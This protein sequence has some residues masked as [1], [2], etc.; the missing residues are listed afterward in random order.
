MKGYAASDKICGYFAG[1]TDGISIDKIIL[2]VYTVI[3][4]VSNMKGEHMRRT[5]GQ[6]IARLQRK[7]IPVNLIVCILCIIASLSLFFMPLV[8]LELGVI[9]GN[10]TIKKLVCDFAVEKVNALVEDVG[11]ETG[12]E[13]GGETPEN[14]DGG[15][16]VS[17][18][19]K[20][21]ENDGTGN[22]DGA[23]NAGGTEGSDGENNGGD[24][25]TSIKDLLKEINVR[26]L[27]EPIVNEVMGAIKASVSVSA[28]NSLKVFMAQDKAE[29]FLDELFFNE[30]KGFVTQLE[31]TLVTGFGTAFD[32]AGKHVQKAVVSAVVAPAIKDNLPAEYADLVVAEELQATIDSLDEVKS[33]QE[34]SDTIINYIDSLSEGKD[35][36]APL[37]EEQKAEVSK[38][39]T[40][41]Y[42]KTVE[43]TR[44]EAT[45][46]DN[47]SVEAMISVI[48]SEMMGGMGDFDLGSIIGG[49]INPDNQPPADSEAP[50]SEYTPEEKT[51]VRL[52]LLG[53]LVLAE[54]ET[55]GGEVPPPSENPDGG[56]GT[57]GEGTENPD[58]TGDKEVPKYVTYRAMGEG[59]ARQF[60]GE[61]FSATLKTAVVDAVGGNGSVFGVYGYVFLGIGFFILMWVILFLFAFFHMFARNKRFMT[62]YVKLFCFWPCIIFFIVPLAAKPVLTSVFPQIYEQV[63]DSIVQFLSGSLNVAVDSAA[64][65]QI[66][67]AALS[68]IKTAAWISGVCYLLLW[69]ISI[70]W[71]FPIKHKIRKL[72]KGL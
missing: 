1:F 28:N 6:E 45:G 60:I 38:Q 50:Q 69:L 10:E 9:V 3:Y 53:R 59:F 54:G 18:L 12:G 22:T 40:E 33:A 27:V 15:E 14:P 11:G 5:R 25:G 19:T 62:W 16:T 7:L 39:I 20:E 72:K 61:D 70:F 65:G 41:L 52:V 63:C 71:A 67:A 46:Q 48:A 26:E 36:L 43:H 64:A 37:T 17:A 4:L 44:D 31:A 34:A 42:D 57:G 51:A 32:T 24:S 68:A 8:K 30:A 49:F 35:D 55:D 47:F 13:S 29:K 58:G 56:E 21:G 66:F 2:R 23:G